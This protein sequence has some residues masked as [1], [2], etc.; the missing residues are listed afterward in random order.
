MYPL[1]K[2]EFTVGKLYH[3]M[4][5]NLK[6]SH[7]YFLI[8]SFIWMLTLN[9]WTEIESIMHTFCPFPSLKG[10]SGGTDFIL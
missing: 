7:V 10:K 6:Q 3:N 1:Q 2:W 9:L 8:L 5:W 4:L